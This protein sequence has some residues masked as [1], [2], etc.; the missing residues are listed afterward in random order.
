MFVI[1]LLTQCLD[2]SFETEHCHIDCCC[3]VA[4]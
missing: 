2:S 3:T 4:V 1:Y